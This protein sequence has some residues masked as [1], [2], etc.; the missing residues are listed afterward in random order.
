[1]S[2]GLHERTLNRYKN[3]VRS[4]QAQR[5]VRCT[6]LRSTGRASVQE[7]GFE[8]RRNLGLVEREAVWRTAAS[9]E[10]QPAISARPVGILLWS[11]G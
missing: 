3:G 10:R 9:D 4:T 1:M 2:L 11:S 5:A 8:T 6:A 7:G